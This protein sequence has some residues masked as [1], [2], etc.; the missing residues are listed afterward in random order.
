MS[1]IENMRRKAATQLMIGGHRGH[2]AGFVPEEGSAPRSAAGDGPP[3]AQLA[4]CPVRE[5][6]IANFECVKNMGLSHIE[7]DLQ[8]TSDDEVV[9]YHDIELS[10]RSPLPGRVREHTLAALKDA[11]DI[12]TLDEVLAWCAAADMPVALELK[13]IPIDMYETMPVLVG[14]LADSLERHRMADMS[15]VLSTDHAS[16]AL[17]K[18]LIPKAN[19]APIVPHVPKN[20]VGLMRELDALI[21]L[22]FA[23]NLYPDLVRTIQTAGYYVDGSVINGTH[24]LKRALWLGVDMI[25]SDCPANIM[26]QY[27][28]ITKA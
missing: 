16:L 19:L 28:R 10:Q 20:P 3:R 8:L 25:E 1:I 15:F 14:R 9:V 2:C 6:T 4:A 12:N 22:C 5:N 18:R 17:L 27:R 23:E 7:V 21:Y 11:F 13:C 24:R 26:E